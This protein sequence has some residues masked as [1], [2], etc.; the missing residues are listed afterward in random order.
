MRSA[1]CG[2]QTYSLSKS[3]GLSAEYFVVLDS[4][5]RV[6]MGNSLPFGG[7]LVLCCG[8]AKQL[9]PVE[10]T[11]I[12]TS[13]NMCTMMDIFVFKADVRVRDPNLKF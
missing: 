9:P 5:L 7:K 8:D 1:S 2:E 3:L 11:M 12:W 6:L 4:I 10:G 13:L